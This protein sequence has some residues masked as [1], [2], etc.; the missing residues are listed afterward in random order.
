MTIKRRIF[1]SFLA[2]LVVP[3]L[4]IGLAMGA[5]RVYY[6]GWGGGERRSPASFFSLEEPLFNLNRRVLEDPDS[7][8]QKDV[9]AEFSSEHPFRG[10]AVLRAGRLVDASPDRLTP[11]AVEEALQAG[12]WRG[13]G[14]T[15]RQQ[16][17][18]FF[19]WKF[20]FS[21]GVPGTFLLV[22]SREHYSGSGPAGLLF[23]LGLAVFLFLVN[24]GITWL[25]AGKIVRPLRRLEEAAES[26]GSGDLDGALEP[27]GDREIRRVFDAFEMMRRELKA[28]LE[29]QLAYER[30]R[31]ELVA[32]LSHDLRTPITSI[33]GY[34]EGLRDGIPK[35]EEARRR[36]LA[37]IDEKA[38][39]L[40][41]LIGDLFLFSRMELPGYELKREPVAAA[42]FVRAVIDDVRQ[43]NPALHVAWLRRDP[44]SVAADRDHLRRALVNIVENSLRHG[45]S[46][47]PRLDLS[48]EADAGLCRIRIADNG[49]GVAP[50]E[51]E[52]IFA[53]LYRGD[54]SR[55]QRSGG[56]GLGLAVV[57]QVAG[58]H[59][60]RTW[61]ERLSPHGLAVV[62][63]L[64]ADGRAAGEMDG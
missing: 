9:L 22:G 46:A 50:G 47:E 20:S 58:A 4:L 24:G 34:V 11:A 64:P 5:V 60:G 45:E 12:L 10:A 18:L 17:F 61:A 48:V 36:Y 2:L 21:D 52:R 57:R 56:S 32:A 51:E 49:K 33:R 63:E 53:G 1:L 44:C 3:V 7:L 42:D 25:A 54:E 35:D 30:G 59:G 55:N 14:S 39:L 40:D 38:R 26:I 23:L 37:V 31:R 8:L 15:R 28:S 13:I 43:E 29:K 6:E 19:Q 62:M 27:E 16:Y 41:R